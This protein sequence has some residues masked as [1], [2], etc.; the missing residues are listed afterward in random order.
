[1]FPF[2]SVVN[3]PMVF[4]IHSPPNEYYDPRFHPRLFSKDLH[5][6]AVSNR[7]RTLF[8]ERGW[9]V[10]YVVHNGF[11]IDKKYFSDEKIGYFLSLGIITPRKGHHLAIEVAQKLGKNLVISGNLDPENLQYFE[12]QIKPHVTDFI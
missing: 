9:N 12:E 7:I 6:C 11:D 3:K 1:M 8:N 4:T 2:A 10:K 5:I